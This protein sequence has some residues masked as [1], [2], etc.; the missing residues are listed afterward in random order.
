MDDVYGLLVTIDFPDALTGG[1][2][3]T[4]DALRAVIE[5]TRGDLTNALVAARLRAAIAS[6]EAPPARRKIRTK[7]TTGG[8]RVKIRRVAIAIVV[9]LVAASCS[10]FRP[11]ALSLGA[12]HVSVGPPGLSGDRVV[13]VTA[14]GGVA[15]RRDG[16]RVAG[17][18]ERAP[19]S[20]P[21]LL[22]LRFTL[23]GDRA[24]PGVHRLIATSTGE[25]AWRRALLERPAAEPGAGARV[26][27]QLS[28]RADRRALL[29]DPTL[30]VH[31]LAARRAVRVRGGPPDRAR[32][33]RRSRRRWTPGGPHPRRR[34]RHHVRALGRVPPDREGVVRRASAPP[35]DRDPHRAE[36]LR[37]RRV[38]DSDPPV[39]RSGDGQ[40]RR[41]DPFG[42]RAA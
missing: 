22:P 28:R 17:P 39:G 37:C 30:A 27:Q 23:A 31:A 26:A 40:A 34:L 24:G 18:A 9:V 10:H 29:A 36:G 42:V 41:G 20:R 32:R 35:P 7:R 21:A 5:R 2:R 13:E 25:P 12:F 11:A 1:L 33:V 4:T 3:R 16:V 6:A 19:R 8:E 38:P 15:G 14:R